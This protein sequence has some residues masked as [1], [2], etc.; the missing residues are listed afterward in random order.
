MVLRADGGAQPVKGWKIVQENRRGTKSEQVVDGE[1]YTFTMPSC[2]SLTV[3]AVF[4]TSGIRT[5]TTSGQSSDAW[6][7]LDG[8]RLN[9]RPQQRGIYIHA[10]RKT[11]VSDL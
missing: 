1:Q 6:F 9:G 7:S 4:E 10:G 5:M 3:N 2:K 11:V 8:R